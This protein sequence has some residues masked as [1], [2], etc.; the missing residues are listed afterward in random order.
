[1]IRTAVI[2]LGKAAEQLHLPACA[3]IP[4]M[5]VVAGCDSDVRR[6]DA[7]RTRF[8]IPAVY[9]DAQTMIAREKPDFVI[10]VTPPGTHC[11]MV[12]LALENGAHVLCEKPFMQTPDQADTVIALAD[13]QHKLLRV[14]NQYRYMATY[15]TPR[16]HIARGDYGRAYFMQCWQQMYHPNNEDATAWRADLHQSTLYEFG[17]HALDLISL[18]F[19]DA[20]PTHVH[21]VIPNVHRKFT[22]DVLIQLTLTFPDDRMATLMFNRVSHAPERYLEMRLDCEDASL[23]LSLGGIARFSAEIGRYD[24]RNFPSLR[25]GWVRGGQTRV[26]QRGRSRIIAAERSA[27]FASATAAHLSE[28]VAM[29]DADNIDNAR[30][31]HAR[32]MLRVIFAGYESA[33]IGKA[34]QL[35]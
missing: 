6:R 7:M 16:Q 28:M 29:I 13:R 5:H 9:D 24:G 33:R 19:D 1:M 21:A 11:E 31:R 32:D 12:T 34:I 26:E 27:A 20:I 2:G 14:N 15:A 18:Y 4:G 17:S 30:A 25:V 23:R 35:T 3:R 8:A 10:V 22:S